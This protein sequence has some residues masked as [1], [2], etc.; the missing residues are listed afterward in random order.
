[1]RAQVEHSHDDHRHLNMQQDSPTVNCRGKIHNCNVHRRIRCSRV[2]RYLPA[3]LEASTIL[4]IPSLQRKQ[5]SRRCGAPVLQVHI[6]RAHNPV[7][8]IET[9]QSLSSTRLRP[10]VSRIYVCHLLHTFA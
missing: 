9:E 2:A 4:I 5:R 3:P 8:H 6:D 1:M 10:Q 7:N